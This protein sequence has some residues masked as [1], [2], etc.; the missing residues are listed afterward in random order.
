M[1]LGEN[2]SFEVSFTE[3]EIFA[4]GGRGSC[5]FVSNWNR[6]GRPFSRSGISAVPHRK[7]EGNSGIFGGPM[8]VKHGAHPVTGAGL[9]QECWQLCPSQ[10]I[11]QS[12]ISEVSG[13]GQH[14]PVCLFHLAVPCS[15]ISVTE[16]QR[17][18]LRVV[19][20]GHR[21][22]LTLGVPPSLGPAWPS[23]SPAW[24]AEGANPAP[25]LS[26]G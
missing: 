26:H 24:R 20:L 21:T 19:A 3:M 25:G 12:N 2:E 10:S 13:Q 17:I 8:C 15:S 7:E 14:V 4:L 23:S 16:A 1:K 18:Q 6:A 5:A 11:N 22:Q 9:N